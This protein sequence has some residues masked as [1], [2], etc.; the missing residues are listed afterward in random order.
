MFAG[1]GA[2]FYGMGR[3]LRGTSPVFDRSLRELDTMFA[4]AGLP[5]VLGEMHRADRVVS[6]PFDR[7]AYTHPAI[8]MVELALLDMLRA[9][10]VLPDHVLG[11]SLGEYAAAATAGVLDREHLTRAIT[12]QVKLTEDLCPRGAMLAVLGDVSGFDP[13]ADGWAGLELAAINYDRH[14]VVSGPP[15][16]VATAQ[17]RLRREG[18]ACQRLPVHYAFHSTQV[19][20]AAEPYQR[21]IATIPLAKPTVELV[22]CA[23]AAVTAEV[24]PEHMWRTIRG[25]IRFADAIKML[26]AHH[27]GLRYVDLGPSPTMARFAERNFR[28]GSGAEAIAIIDPFAPADRGLNALRRKAVRRTSTAGAVL[29]PGQG[30]Q[31]VGMAGELFVEF[32]DLVAEADEIL[33]YSIEELCLRDPRGELN[34]TEFTQPALFVANALHY[35]NWQR[36]HGGAPPEFFA[37]HSLGEYN[38]LWAAGAFDFGTGLR[39]VRRR[40][41]LMSKMDEGAMAAVV[42]IGEG[43]V[44]AVLSGHG[45]TDVDIANVNSPDQLVISGPRDVVLGAK[46]AFADAGARYL[47]LRVSG[48]FHSRH[49]APARAQFEDFLASLDIRPPRIPVIANVTAEPYP[50]GDIRHLL[51]DQLV[52]PVRWADS[53]RYLRSHGVG[54]LTEVGPGTVLTKLVGRIPAPV[55]LS[56][57]PGQ[58]LGSAEFRETYGLRYAYVCGSMYRGISSVDMVVRAGKAGML[59]FFGTGGLALEH[60]GDAIDRIRAAGGPFGMS[61]PHSRVFRTAEDDLVALFLRRDVRV[62]EASGFTRITPALA[63]YRAG[64]LR[65][66]QNRV[67]AENRIIAKV[68]RPD[69]AEQFLRPP[70]EAML[71][72][73]RADGLITAEQAELAASTPVADDLVVTADSGGHTDRGMLLWL[74]PSIMRL[75]DRTARQVRVGAAGGIGTPAAA[76]AAF[77]LGADFVV[78]GSVN[79]CT[80]EAGLS[81]VAKDM[82]AGITPWDTD[83]APAGDQLELGGQAQ[84][85]GRGV[86][87]PARARR[88]REL[89]LRHDSLDA[90]DPRTSELLQDRWFRRS[91]TDIWQD[92][93]AYL[94]GEVER[95]DRDPKH[96]MA[97]VLRWYFGL[98][99]RLAIEGDEE[100]RVDFQVQCG[101]ALGAYNQGNASAWRDRHVDDIAAELMAATAQ[102]VE[103]P[104]LLGASA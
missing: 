80:A 28:T 89:Y 37:G 54:R 43:E 11:S 20:V 94:P 26:E 102:L 33:G 95:A 75:R 63:R 16:A 50:D 93:T 56:P 24:T 72:D 66:D 67:V 88:L 34:S 2:Q 6:D 76:A 73:L 18:T 13:R 59:A 21:M 12:A 91:F 100:R 70:P 27:D 46:Q 60:V 3:D 78:T 58:S 47:A 22:S 30:S 25:P 51:A 101:P 55:T 29:F 85:L 82:L 79:L 68:S 90:L 35:K 31:S 74:L 36:E 83:Y 9:E 40:G 42:G 15:D 14:F 23:T 99:Q 62:V 69:V 7:F 4:D 32:P 45:L 96:R 17:G 103:A 38:A 104:R 57:H 87:F 53:V 81:D 8:L 98:S 19:D 61:L 71:R 49:M 5:G 48:A 39:L 52:R 41:E 1:Q 10:D 84:V 64:G 86:L 97:L 44:R 65:R 92:V 77:L